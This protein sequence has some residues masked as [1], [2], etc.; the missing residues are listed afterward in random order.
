[1]PLDYGI[2]KA[3]L[4]KM[5]DTEPTG[6]ESKEKYLQRLRT[7]A[8]SLPRSLVKKIIQRMKKNI[9]GVIDADGYHA[10]DD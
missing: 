10:K 9:Q 8:L 3:I 7:C 4:D 6:R 5:E 1:M 2:W